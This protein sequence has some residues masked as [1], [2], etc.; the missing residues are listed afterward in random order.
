[1][2]SGWDDEKIRM[3]GSENGKHIW[4]I[5]NAHKK[6]VTSIQLSKNLKFLCS[7]GEEGDVRVWEMKSRQMISHLKEHWGKI[8]NIYLY[9]D[10]IHLVSSSRD[11]TILLWDLKNEKRISSNQQRMGGINNFDVTPDQKLVISTGQDRK[12]T[13]WDLNQPRPIRLLT[14][15]ENPKLADECNALCISHDGHLFATGGTNQVVRIWDVREGKVLGV[16]YGH[17]DS[18]TCLAFSHDDKQVVSTGLDGS[19]LLWNIF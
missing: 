18:V 11:K 4:S 5:D 9:D 1:V 7:G 17:S 15:N 8:T 14:S 19:I 2:I 3:F 13:Y 16:G 6:A 10:D 12:I